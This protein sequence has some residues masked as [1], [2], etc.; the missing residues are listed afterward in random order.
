MKADDFHAA[1]QR[2]Q[3][4]GARKVHWTGKNKPRQGG[5]HTNHRDFQPRMLIC[6]QCRKMPGGS[7]KQF[8]SHWPQNQLRLVHFTAASKQ[9]GSHM[10]TYGLKYN[11]WEKTKYMKSSQT[12]HCTRKTEMVVKLKANIE[13]SRIVKVTGHKNIQS[14]D[15]CD[16]ANEDQER[17]LSYAISGRNNFKST[18]DSIQ[19][20]SWPTRA[21]CVFSSVSSTARSVNAIATD[22]NA[23][24]ISVW[25]KP[26]FHI[27][28]SN[29]TRVL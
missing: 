19:R 26:K 5:L 1:L 9:T 6:G 11:H 10:A 4:R 13:R 20:S 3:W 24:F 12:Y 21:A 22:F 16:E 15:D 29:M 27:A 2:R 23:Q 8:A 25:I 7:F 18:T 14:F 17:W 28:Q